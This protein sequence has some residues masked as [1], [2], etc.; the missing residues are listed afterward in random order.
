MRR[1]FALALALPALTLCLAAQT[2]APAPAKTPPAAVDITGNWHCQVDY[3]GTDVPVGVHLGKDSSGA[4]TASVD[5]VTDP[6]GPAMAATAKY[7]DGQLHLDVP[8]VPATF[9]GTL[10]TAGDTIAGAWSVTDGNLS[11]SLVK[12]GG[13]A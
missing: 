4:L 7:Q 5:N 1:F 6:S 10:N 11:C 8:S 3:N 13:P 9:D 12:G 2:P